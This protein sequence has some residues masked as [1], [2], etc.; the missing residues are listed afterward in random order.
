MDLVNLRQ[1]LREEKSQNERLTQ[2][3]EQLKGAYK[4]LVQA[5]LELKDRV[6]QML[7]QPREQESTQMEMTRNLLNIKIT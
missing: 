3:N 2:E 1:A 6:S 4:S 7:P 5:N